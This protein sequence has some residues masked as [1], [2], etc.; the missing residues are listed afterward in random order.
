M[1][2]IQFKPNENKQKKTQ[3]ILNAKHKQVY[4]IK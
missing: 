1:D 4:A 2:S 3:N